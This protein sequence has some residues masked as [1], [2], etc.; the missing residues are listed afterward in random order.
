[1]EEINS[2]LKDLEGKVKLEV[3]N[4]LNEVKTSKDEIAYKNLDRWSFQTGSY[5][6]S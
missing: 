2:Y 1:M 5:L 3:F 4:L 6:S